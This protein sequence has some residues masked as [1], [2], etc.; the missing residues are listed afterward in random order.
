VPTFVIDAPEG[1]AKSPSC[2]ISHRIDKRGLF[3]AISS[4]ITSYE[5]RNGTKR[6][7]TVPALPRRTQ[8]STRPARRKA[9]DGEETVRSRRISRAATVQKRRAEMCARPR[10]A[11]HFR[12]YVRLRLPIESSCV[13]RPATSAAHLTP[14]AGAH[15]LEGDRSPIAS[16]S[17]TSVAPDTA[18]KSRLL[19]R[20][21]G[22][23]DDVLRED[24]RRAHR[25]RTPEPSKRRRRS[26]RPPSVIEPRSRSP[27]DGFST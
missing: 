12:F 10:R 24:V 27:H 7:A 2:Q 13:A 25:D 17:S 8:G 1:A 14:P 6:C 15:S 22:S 5:S 16:S 11:H 21:S 19:P 3:S 23:S 4:V 9:V 26:P 20:L 18:R